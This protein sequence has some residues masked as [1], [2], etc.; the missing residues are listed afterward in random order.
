M[1]D[2]EAW[3]VA[4]PPAPT[5]PPPTVAA[6]SRGLTSLLQALVMVGGVVGA[7]ILFIVGAVVQG[8]LSTSGTESSG[9][10]H[11]LTTGIFLLAAAVFAGGF[12]I[13]YRMG[14][15]DARARGL[16]GD[17]AR[18]LLTWRT[19]ISP[20]GLSKLLFLPR[21]IYGIDDALMTRL[22]LWRSYLGVGITAAV[23]VSTDL[24]ALTSM[25]PFL[26]TGAVNSFVL[27]TAVL[28]LICAFLVLLAGEDRV[29]ALRSMIRPGL[30]LAGTWALALGFVLLLDHVLTPRLEAAVVDDDAPVREVAAALLWVALT[31]WLVAFFCFSLI[32]ITRHMFASQDAHP[33]VPGLACA[34]LSWAFLGLGAWAVNIGEWPLL[35]QAVE[36]PVAGRL[37]TLLT[38]GG[39]VSVTALAGWEILRVRALGFRVRPWPRRRYD[40]D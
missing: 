30:T 33:V 8:L 39:A 29:R 9:V 6:R 5:R 14:I 34:A 12:T 25:A 13:V 36:L 22:A 31:A 7:A 18:P 32:F 26:V 19:V 1:R 27:G 37:T 38:V 16:P 28:V 35:F 4:A 23:I 21:G 15:A 17:S 11:P 10:G 3:A 40:R 20:R 2:H 24:G